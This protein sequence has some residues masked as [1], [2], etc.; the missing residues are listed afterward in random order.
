MTDQAFPI[1]NHRLA[2][3]SGIAKAGCTASTVK[4]RWQTGEPPDLA[5]LLAQQPELKDYR[6]V[7]LDLAYEEYRLRLRAGEK[8]D[9]G[10]F[11]QRFPSLERSLYLLIVVHS[12]LG[13]DSEADEQNGAIAWPEPGS[14]FLGFNLITEIGRGGFGRV[15]LASERA[16]GERPVVLKVALQ[17]AQE[18][19]MLARLRHP[20]IVPVY[21]VR[22]DDATGLSGICM[23]FLGQATLAIVLD[24]VYAHRRPPDQAGA[25]L[26]AIRAANAGL[27]ST[28]PVEPPRILRTGSYVEGVIHLAAELADALAHAHRC[29]ICHRDLKPS[30]ILLSPAGRPLLLDFN[31]AIEDD[32]PVRK[33]GGTLPYMAPEELARICKEPAGAAASYDPSSDLFSLGVIVY[34]LLTGSL[35]FGAIAGNGSVEE[36]ARDLR[37]RQAQGPPPIRQRN[38]QV[39]KRLA[40][41]IE[42]CLA[43]E[44][45]RRPKG[46]AELAA[47]LRSEL[48]FPRRTRRWATQHRWQVATAGTLLAAALLGAAAYLVLRPPYSVR[49]F[50]EGMAYY[51]T[52]KDDLAIQCL[53]VSLHAD[54]HSR[55]TLLARARAYQRL[56]EFRMAIEDYRAA[57]DL[58]PSP[59][60]DACAAYCMS[61]IDDHP[62]AA[63]FYGA[64]LDAGCDSPAV[65]NDFGRSLICLGRLDEAEGCLRRAIGRNDSPQAAYHNLIVIFLRR[66][67]QTGETPPR[68]ALACAARAIEIGPESV[69]LCQHVATLTVLAATRDPARLRSA[70]EYVRKAIA[71]G[72]DAEVFRSAPT[73]RVLQK[74]PAFQRALAEP[75]GAATVNVDY[76]VALWPEL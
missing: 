8:L 47:A 22:Q 51:K 39:D 43:L 11:A 68:E 76:L 34:E 55:E 64:A 58:A 31:L 24:T 73:F 71:L 26:A 37:R 12:L 33:I 53:N 61:R 60:I 45:E 66:A 21:S 28:E 10:D 13:C 48:A 7:V 42:S 57:D 18:A 56:G 36:T 59:W 32:R 38:E 5:A 52:G 54:P 17:G 2:D 23:P 35:P 29:G 63:A 15:F 74:D 44:A 4:Q 67:L 62:A 9:A 30:N 14:H 75:K 3:T 46:P 72:A 25:I 19:K 65:L 41:L 69:E 16:L 40:R 50:R 70:V 1:R 20:N 49:Q 6:S 27:E